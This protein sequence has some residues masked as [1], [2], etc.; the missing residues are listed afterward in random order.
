MALVTPCIAHVNEK[1]VRGFPVK[2]IT[3]LEIRSSARPDIC[4]SFRV[5]A[6]HGGI[7]SSLRSS[8]MWLLD[9]GWFVPQVSNIL[10]VSKRQAPVT[11]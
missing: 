6:Y 4:A 1:V 8:D 10:V 11:Q 5:L 2:P 3:S 9:I 7:S